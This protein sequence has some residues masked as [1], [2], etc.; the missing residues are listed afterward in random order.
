M[1]NLKDHNSTACYSDGIQEN[2]DFLV[3]DPVNDSVAVK[4]KKKS[5]IQEDKIYSVSEIC[6][7]VRRQL[8]QLKDVHVSGEVLDWSV[9]NGF[10]FFSL[11]QLGCIIRCFISSTYLNLVNFEVKTGLKVIVTGD[12][13]FIKK[14]GHLSLTVKFIKLE[15]EGDRQKRLARILATLKEAG[16]LDIHKSLPNVI[17]N[18]AVITSIHGQAI[19]DVISTIKR[20]NRFIN[21]Y[22][23]PA[24]VQGTDAPLSLRTAFHAANSRVQYYNFDAILIV[25]GGGS[26][27]DLDCFNDIDLNGYLSYRFVPVI[28]GVGHEG[29]VTIID[30][31]ADYRAATPTAA[32][33]LVSKDLSECIDRFS[34]LK[35]TLIWQLLTSIEKKKQQLARLNAE[36]KQF[37]TVNVIQQQYAKLYK[38]RDNL[39]SLMNN[40]LQSRKLNLQNINAQL[41]RCDPS[42]RLSNWY[43]RLNMLKNKLAEHIIFSLR[44][45]ENNIATF[46]FKLQGG[47]PSNKIKNFQ[48]EISNLKLKLINLMQENLTVKKQI[49]LQNATRLDAISPLKVL[50]KGYS[51]TTINGKMLKS[52]DGLKE[53]DCITTKLAH[54]TVFSKVM[55]CNDD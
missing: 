48:H 52:V 51:Y 45:Y 17:R 46:K 42:V 18:V 34:V 32:A 54:G 35:R 13:S 31:V 41:H 44:A 28:S 11:T 55:S 4:N 29:D 20:R 21:I 26:S 37:S 1:A 15:G 2:L 24:I 38:A 19:L 40:N 50:E 6:D 43:L 10:A 3:D 5:L 53:G 22:V 30:H 8:L 16:C 39:L 14:S 23:F 49:F 25:R 33:E 7:V 12:F 9:K 27:D 47:A 36:L